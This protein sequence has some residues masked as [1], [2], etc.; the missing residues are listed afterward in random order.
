VLVND[1]TLVGLNACSIFILSI[2]LFMASS[3]KGA[4]FL[5][6][7]KLF[8]EPTQNT[9]IGFVYCGFKLPA[10]SKSV[11]FIVFSFNGLI[12]DEC[13]NIKDSYPKIE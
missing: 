2:I 5:S 9:E 13:V 7:I 12:Y 6:L 1:S 11:N 3:I 8:S 4:V 10:K